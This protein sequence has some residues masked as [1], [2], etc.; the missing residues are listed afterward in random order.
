VN[1]TATTPPP[2]VIDDREW[3]RLWERQFDQVDR[4]RY[5]LAVWRGEQPDDALGRRVVPELARRWRRR[6]LVYAAA[7]ALFTAFWVLVG[8]NVVHHHGAEGTF[9]PWGCAGVGAA[10][11]MGCLVARVR[12][13][14]STHA[15]AVGRRR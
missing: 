3:D 4:H 6:A 10:V 12:F 14:R 15:T 9:V 2:L 8:I 1:T 11:V 13:A 7:W 5:G